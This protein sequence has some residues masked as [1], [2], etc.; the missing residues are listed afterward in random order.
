[1]PVIGRIYPAKSVYPVR[2]D[3]YRYIVAKEA[4]A[5][6]A[7]MINRSVGT[8]KRAAVG[9]PGGKLWRPDYPDEQPADI[10]GYNAAPTRYRSL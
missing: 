9:G 2:I 7:S 6:G 3:T 8:E 5:A 4:V 10:G 1:M